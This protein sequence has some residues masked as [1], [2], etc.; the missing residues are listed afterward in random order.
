M[1]PSELHEIVRVAALQREVYTEL[2]KSMSLS[3]ALKDL[4]T[5]NDTMRRWQ[6]DIGQ[7]H[8]GITR[9]LQI[10]PAI[11]EALEEFEKI[12]KRISWFNEEHSRA[13][14]NWNQLIG[15]FIP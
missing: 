2:T 7:F 1:K 11:F 3:S 13:L 12:Q 15:K 6:S 8:A 9:A 5:F 4:V 10:R 14:K